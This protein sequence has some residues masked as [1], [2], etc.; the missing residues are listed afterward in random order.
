MTLQVYPRQQ[1]LGERV[2][3]SVTV[4]GTT[5]IRS[6]VIDLGD[7]TVVH[8]PQLHSWSCPPSPREAGAG[9]P[10]HVYAAPGTY[11]V[12]AVVTAVPCSILP[13][14]PG[15]WTGPDGQPAV[16]M[17]TPWVP[18]GPDRTVSAA[19]GVHQRPDRPPPPVGPPPGP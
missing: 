3:V 19:I 8:A 13:G 17:P 2:Q 1:Y 5:A 12:S 15:G 14:P 16:G 11:R 4:A 9:V 7:G 10:A 18:A 6:I